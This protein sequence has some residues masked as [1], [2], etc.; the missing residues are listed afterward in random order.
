MVTATLNQF[1]SKMKTDGAARQNRFTVIISNP[2]TTLNTELVQLYCEQA[3]LP[4]ISFASQPVRTYGEQREV[5]YDR[6]FEAIT[7]TFIVDRQFKVKEFF[8][9]WANMIVDPTTRLVGYYEKYAK[10]IKIITQDTKDNN[11]YETE[12]FEAYPKTIGAITLDHN[13]KDIAKLQVTFS[14]KHHVNNRLQS[15]DNDK[16]PKKLFGLDLP[17]PYK[18]SAQAGAYLRDSISN[19]INIP[20]LYYDNFQQFQESVADKFAISRIERQGQETGSGIMDWF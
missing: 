5:V 7:L 1:I 11:T 14:Y 13:S 8:D 10:N 3:S 12:L 6:T 19:A 15:P 2:A 20:D 4:S 9:E 16:Q 18:L 17:D